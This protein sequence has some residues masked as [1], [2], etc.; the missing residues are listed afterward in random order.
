ML[1][2]LTRRYKAAAGT[3]KGWLSYQDYELVASLFLRLL[4]VIYLIAFASLLVQIQGLV[5]SQGI[6]PVA[7][8]LTHVTSEV[9][10]D[11][12]YRLPTLFR[13]QSGG[14]T[15]TAGNPRSQSRDRVNRS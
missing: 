7:D 5:G 3:V 9:G 2:Q 11:R 12:Y 4:G 13:R 10:S 14:R 6:L 1:M 8:L 15:E